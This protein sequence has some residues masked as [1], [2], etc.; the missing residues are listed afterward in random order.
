[1]R[2]SGK[3][4][5]VTGAGSGIG[6]ATVMAFAKEGARVAAF[7]V[8]AG[9]KATEDAALAQGYAVKAYTAN[10]ADEAS[11]ITGFE[12]AEAWLG[13]LDILINS[14]GIR[15]LAPAVDLPVAE[16]RRILDV[17]VTGTFICARTFARR[18]I[19]LG[20]RGAIVNFGST[21]S[22]VAAPNRPAYVSSKHAVLGLTKEM[23]MELGP[24]GIRVNAVGPGLTRTGMTEQF[25]SDPS[26]AST[27]A[28]L[29][30]LG[31]GADVEEMTPAVLF[32]ASD[33][34][35]FVTGSLLLADGGWT[36]GKMM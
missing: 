33:E 1:M 32:L 19:A 28:S 35:S 21:L 10:V 12:Q 20:K 2:F 34:A 7:D 11:V 24:K 29:H 3:N 18:L 9:A 23:A 22:V 14:A 25:F 26:M 15:E 8:T 27:I 31:R 13:G 4:V 16:F 30:A 36:A 17:N 6:R 5:I